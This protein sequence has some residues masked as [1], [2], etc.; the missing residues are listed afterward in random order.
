MNQ[1]LDAF[2]RQNVWDVQ[3]VSQLERL[4]GDLNRIIG[5]RVRYW[6]DISLICFASIE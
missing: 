2:G 3:V 6:N 4:L 1:V 5:N